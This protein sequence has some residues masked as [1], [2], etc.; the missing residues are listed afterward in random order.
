MLVASG[1][2]KAGGDVRRVVTVENQQRVVQN[3]DPPCDTGHAIDASEPTV[4]YYGLV[5]E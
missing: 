3:S 2:T 4:Y 1:I 5:M